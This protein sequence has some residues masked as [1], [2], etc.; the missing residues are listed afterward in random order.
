VLS[1]PERR[2][3]VRELRRITALDRQGKFRILPEDEDGLTA[4]EKFL[5][6][7]LGDLGKKIHTARSRNDQVVAALRL[8]C[9]D[10]LASVERLIDSCVS[11]L[12]RRARET[13]S[14]RVPGYTHARKAMPSTFAGWFEAFAESMGDTG[15]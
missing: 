4:I 6:S 5:I 1:E 8:Y 14:I 11:A 2:R 10:R 7:A 13:R 9:R 15:S 12:R 3:L